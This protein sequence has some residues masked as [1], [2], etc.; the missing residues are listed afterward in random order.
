MGRSRFLVPHK[1]RVRRSFPV[2]LHQGV[3]SLNCGHRLNC[4]RSAECFGT[5]LRETEVQNFP[6]FG[7]IFNGT[8]YVFDWHFWIDAVSS[9]QAGSY[10]LVRITRYQ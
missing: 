9:R 2:S 4:M 6:C 1:S 7:Q 3:F 8:S 10:G 5:R